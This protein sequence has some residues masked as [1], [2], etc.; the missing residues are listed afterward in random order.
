RGRRG[1]PGRDDPVVPGFRGTAA[2]ADV[3]EPALGLDR[4]RRGPLVAHG[5][6]GARHLPDR[7]RGQ[8]RGRRPAC[9]ARPAP[10]GPTVSLL[11]VRDLAVAFGRGTDAPRALDGISFSLEVGERVALVGESGSGKTVT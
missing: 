10:D 2:D 11:A 5:V 3:G 7:A 4:H 9:R 1:D 8:L 6:P